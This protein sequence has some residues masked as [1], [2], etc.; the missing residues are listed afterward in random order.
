[1][2][3]LTDPPD[4]RYVM[5]TSAGSEQPP[6]LGLPQRAAV[7]ALL[8][9]GLCFTAL[10]P[11]LPLLRARLH[12][13]PFEAGLLSAMYPM[14]LL[15]AAVPAAAVSARLGLKA[16]L[17]LGLAGLAAGSLLFGL[18]HSY[19]VLVVSQ[20]AVGFSG[21]AVWSATMVWLVKGPDP[22]RRGEII[23]RA[24]GATAIGETLGP[25]VGGV[26]ATVGRLPT[27]AVI[28]GLIAGLTLNSGRLPRAPGGAERLQIG[29]VVRQRGIAPILGINAA[30]G[31]VMSA[32]IVLATLEMHALSLS[33][34]VIAV[35]LLLSACGGIVISPVIGRWSDRR[36]RAEP[37]RFGLGATCVPLIALTTLTQLWAVIAGSMLV[38][39]LIRTSWSPALALLTDACD[40]MSVS[41]INP[42]A[43][44]LIVTSGGFVGGSAI[45]GAIAGLLGI[46]SAWAAIAVVAAAATLATGRL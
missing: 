42:L 30:P 21:A 28:A 6:Y 22:E 25:V 13:T 43:L 9:E 46:R 1:M 12:L 17:T 3:T 11:V 16:T 10:A 45:A 19:P 27:F 33:A 36:G 32:A 5:A 23:G 2:S 4:G 39:I 35:I 24:L 44:A 38:L 7:A 14:G 29:T 41:Q 37:L 31:V 40:R 20:L 34:A 26:A 18:A 15:S 8:F